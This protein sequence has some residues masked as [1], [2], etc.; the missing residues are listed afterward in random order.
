MV[1]S[2]GGWWDGWMV[3]QQ[4]KST[5]TTSS[6]ERRPL[7]IHAYIIH[8]YIIYTYHMYVHIYMLNICIH[9]YIMHVLAAKSAV[10]SAFSRYDMYLPLLLSWTSR[11]ENPRYGTWGPNIKFNFR[12]TLLHIM[13]CTST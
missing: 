4:C 9:I 2:T 1:P 7:T 11:A 10:V 8:T 13:L 12:S 5:L 3:G 6:V